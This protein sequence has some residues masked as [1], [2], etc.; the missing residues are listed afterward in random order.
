MKELV[1]SSDSRRLFSHSD[2]GCV[3]EWDVTSGRMERRKS[4][5]SYTK[6]L[7]LN[8]GSP[9]TISVSGG[10]VDWSQM[11]SPECD[12][13]FA[14]SDLKGQIVVGYR[15]EEIRLIDP[16]T[17]GDLQRRSFG[18]F[19]GLRISTSENLKVIAVS[20]YADPKPVVA[21]EFGSEGE[22]FRSES[23]G[24]LLGLARDGTQLAFVAEDQDPRT[25]VIVDLGTGET[26]HE[27]AIGSIPT[28]G[29][30]A[31]SAN[32]RAVALGGGYDGGHSVVNLDSAEVIEEWIGRHAGPTQA[33][34]FSPDGRR[35]ATGSDDCSI[36]FY[37]LPDPE[38]D[39]GQSIVEDWIE[40]S[41]SGEELPSEIR[42]VLDRWTEETGQVVEDSDAGLRPFFVSRPAPA[43]RVSIFSD[44]CC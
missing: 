39:E 32:G 30:F 29:G 22:I 25:L 18:E 26:I 44:D 28:F 11:S 24:N 33:L 3:A 21:F 14:L 36:R 20:D 2:D 35:V 17:G 15:G 42:E 10:K 5:G 13:D 7:S 16:V 37:R 27:V 4:V 1:F 41:E 23:M 43:Y 19:D 31:F 12:L 9:P 40:Q 6:G 8:E 38:D 34:A